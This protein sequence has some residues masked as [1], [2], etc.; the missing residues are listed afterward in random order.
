MPAACRTFGDRARRVA[1]RSPASSAEKDSS[2]SMSS[3]LAGQGPGERD[4]LLLAARDLVR[5]GA[6]SAASSE[7]ISSSSGDLGLRRLA[8]PSAAASVSMPKAMFWPTVR[9]GKRAPSCAT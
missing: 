7:T 3:R 9:W 1:T 2:S 4:A 6:A 5:A 8:R